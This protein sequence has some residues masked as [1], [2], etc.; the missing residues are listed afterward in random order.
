MFWAETGDLR[1]AKNMP[2]QEKYSGCKDD[3]AETMKVTDG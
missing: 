3:Y 2:Y 1:D